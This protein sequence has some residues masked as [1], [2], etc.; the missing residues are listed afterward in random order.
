MDDDAGTATRSATVTVLSEVQA[1][2]AAAATV[3]VMIG[4]ARL[5]RGPANSL[6]VKLDNAAASFTRGNTIAAVNQAEAALNE[7][8]G[9]VRGGLL[10]EGQAATTRALIVRAI[11]SLNR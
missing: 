1:L 8:D 6:K 9:L 7:L 3:D 2:A 11:A 10:T 4:G 5:N